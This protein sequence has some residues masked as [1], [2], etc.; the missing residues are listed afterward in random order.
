[1]AVNGSLWQNAAMAPGNPPE[2]LGQLLASLNEPYVVIDQ[3]YVIRLANDAYI[4]LHNHSGAEAVV[5]RKCFEVSHGYSLPCDQSGE[6]C[7]LSLSRESGAP[8]RVVHIHRRSEQDLYESIDLTPLKDSEGEIIYFL[9]RLQP[10]QNFSPNSQREGLTGRSPSFL[11]MLEYLNRVS[12]SDTTVLIQGESGTGKELVAR[13]IHDSSKRSLKPFITVDCTGLPEAL[14]ESELFGHEK[15]AFTGAYTLKRGLVEEAD[16][17]TLFLDEIGD[18]PL[19]LQAKLLR[20]LESGTY[21]RVGSN[22]LRH[23]NI[24]LLSATH[25]PLKELVQAGTFRNDLY[26]RISTFPI[27]VPSLRERLEDIPILI[28]SLLKRIEEG[29]SYKV[30]DSALKIMK[31]YSFPGNIRELKN[32]LERA[33]LLCDGKVIEMAHLPNEMTA[34][35][36]PMPKSSGGV[37]MNVQTEAE[38]QNLLAGGLSRRETAQRLG[39]SERTLYRI[40]RTIK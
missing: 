12:P 21:R 22:Q 26:Y 3:H 4:Q 33:V 39:V 31:A 7:P 1:L 13:A 6:S 28:A 9:E 15:G 2:Y 32:I 23:A 17:G 36:E 40:L 16:G 19:G 11:R 5:G 20:F 29:S 10:L 24:R 35:Q 18:I 27:F 37:A 8:E 14:I 38:V 30:S 25:Q 34:P